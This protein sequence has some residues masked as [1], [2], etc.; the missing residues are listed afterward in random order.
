MQA[1][2]TGTGRHQL[3]DEHGPTQLRDDDDAD[4][5]EEFNRAMQSLVDRS[6]WSVHASPL[7]C[8]H[9]ASARRAG[10]TVGECRRL[11]QGVWYQSGTDLVLKSSSRVG[12]SSRARGQSR[13]L[14]V[15]AGGEGA[16]VNGWLAGWL[17]GW[18]NDHA[19]P[20]LA[21]Q[22]ADGRADRFVAGLDVGSQ[23]GVVAFGDP[24]VK[25]F[26]LGHAETQSRDAGFLRDCLRRH[27]VSQGGSRGLHRE[28]A[29]PHS[30]CRIAGHAGR[31]MFQPAESGSKAARSAPT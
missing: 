8:G 30:V 15:R 27:S 14:A 22:P 10:V 5:R 24:D 25:L 31:V 9:D 29:G 11:R 26:L 23:Q 1:P 12:W 18:C 16:F 3:L 19:V 4:V 17:A 20:Q 21:D 13:W 6:G 28:F 2:R 7:R